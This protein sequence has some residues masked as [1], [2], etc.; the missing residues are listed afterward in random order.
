MPSLLRFDA[1]RLLEASLEALGLAVSSLGSQKRVQFRQ[2]SAE[3]AVEVG[4]IG[5]A[6]ELAMSACLVQARGAR[7]IV[8]PSGQYKTASVIL[9]DFQQLVRQST[10]SSSFITEAV[11]DPASHRQSLFDAS[12]SFRRLIPIRAAGLHAG[13]GLV[14]EAVVSLANS[15][16]DFLDLLGGSRRLRPYL[17]RVPRCLWYS[18]DRMLLIEDLSARLNH[19]S[20]PEQAVLLSSIYLV[21]PD[22]P[23]EEPE[24]LDALARVSVA[25]RQRDVEYLM[26]TLDQ[27][28]PA[29]LRRASAIGC[30]IPVRVDNANP[31]ALPIAPHLLRRQFNQIP[32]LWHSDIATANGRLDQGA[33]D[34]PPLDAVLDVFAIGLQRAGVIEDGEQLN[35]HQVWPHIV[36]SLNYSGTIGPYW[37]LVRQ[38]QDL[39]QLAAILTRAAN[40]RIRL[41]QRI[42][43]CLQGLECLRENRAVNRHDS[44]F[45]DL[46]QEIEQVQD[47]RSWLLD[48]QRQYSNTAR[49]L[50]TELLPLLEDVSEGGEPIG[51]L[52]EALLGE[53]RPT[54]CLVYWPRT[55]AEAATE[56]DDIAGLVLVLK[57]DGARAGHTAARK[58]LRRIDFAVFGPSVEE[59]ERQETE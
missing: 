34:L 32:D 31:A 29:T 56:A 17:E 8:W 46:I 41:E 58:A 14:Q 4:L 50:P 12:R 43:E 27:A 10:A 35:A 15:V 53:N 38:C 2:S 23:Q 1:I 28:I 45:D 57:N 33:L 39:G 52:L 36:A 16:A 13:R 20:G 9:V 3:F 54:E 51:A 55:F 49:A 48:R 18:R 19:N 37:F 26:E 42:E 47:D 44:L 40:G 6:A 59:L 21:L 30:T 5:A 11:S 25:P 22:V 24:W 7:A